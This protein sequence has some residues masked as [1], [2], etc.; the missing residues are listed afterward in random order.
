MTTKMIYY[1]YEP[2]VTFFQDRTN[3]ME[4]AIRAQCLAD[5]P[6]V[7]YSVSLALLQ[8]TCCLGVSGQAYSCL[9]FSIND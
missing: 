7:S 6:R 5:R 4:P 3:E 8:L 2:D 9:V 1:T